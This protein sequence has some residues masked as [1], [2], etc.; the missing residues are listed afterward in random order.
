M[1]TPSKKSWG[2]IIPTLFLVGG[3]LFLFLKTNVVM[4]KFISSGYKSHG[5]FS[6]GGDTSDGLDVQALRW[7]KHDGYERLV[8]D[9]YRWRGVIAESTYQKTNEV[10]AYQIGREVVNTTTIDGELSGYRAFSA[11]L[12]SVTKSRFIKDMEVYSDGY[13]SY[14]FAIHLKKEVSYKVFS[15][16]NPARIIIDI[17]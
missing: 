8:F 3:A 15:L 10:G 6:G 9:I 16:K 4:E 11:K 17:K 12:P 5:Y 2:Y 13:S 14:L 7:H 1:K